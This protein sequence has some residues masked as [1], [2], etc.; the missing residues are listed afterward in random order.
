MQS[1]GL[2]PLWTTVVVFA[3]CTAVMTMWRPQ[4]M[5]EVATTPALWVLIV[6]AG[7]TNAAFNWAVSVGDVVRVVLL[8]YLMP[9][10]AVLLAWFLLQEKLTLRSALQIALAL[11]GAAVVLWPERQG[12]ATLWQQVPL[13]RNLSEWL[14]VLGGLGFALNNVMLRREAQRSEAARAWAMFFGGL[15]VSCVLAL[16]LTS[17]G[18]I[19]ALPAL[20]ANWL[21][22]ALGLSLTFL[23]SNMAL[24]Y[25]AARLPSHVTSVVMTSE[26]VFASISAVLWGAGALTAQTGFGGSVVLLAALIS[27]LPTL[28]QATAAPRR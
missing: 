21:L 11:T 9:L 7:T 13:P 27:T 4:A 22:P 25:G 18:L 26:V 10:W 16:T 19:P 24:Q 14:G 28:P 15:L 1:L 6:A 20:Q 12:Q 8:F 3:L 23:T 2:H 17:S 5:R